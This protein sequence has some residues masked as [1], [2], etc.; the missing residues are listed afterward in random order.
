M[1]T[2][3]KE[4]M[5]NGEKIASIYFLYLC[6]FK[7]GTSR[8]SPDGFGSWTYSGRNGSIE[9]ILK[10]SYTHLEYEYAIKIRK[11]V[12]AVVLSD[13]LLHKKAYEDS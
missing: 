7:G 6:G 12:F 10:K 2:S 8:S 11:P 3:D 1:N 9:P 13:S 5:W 4:V